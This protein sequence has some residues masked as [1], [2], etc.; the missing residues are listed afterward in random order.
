M[1]K[2]CFFF[3]RLFCDTHFQ[4]SYACNWQ[5][6]ALIMFCSHSIGNSLQ[7]HS[8]VPSVSLFISSKDTAC[9]SAQEIFWFFSN[10]MS[11]FIISGHIPPLKQLSH[12]QDSQVISKAFRPE[13]S[14]LFLQ[15]TL[16]YLL[17]INYITNYVSLT[18]LCKVIQK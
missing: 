2:S 9:K 16:F 8:V 17:K 15:K 6:D 14:P 11:F 10:F 18:H 1:L 3:L 7:L 12:L 4:T 5:T 13:H